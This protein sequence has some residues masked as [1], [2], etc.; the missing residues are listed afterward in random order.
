MAIENHVP[1]VIEV[2]ISLI[3]ATRN[4]VIPMDI[5][6]IEMVKITKLIIRL[7]LIIV[8]LS[9]VQKKRKTKIITS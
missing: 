8:F 5:D 3:L 9:I 7:P 1:I 6:F 4:M 2:V